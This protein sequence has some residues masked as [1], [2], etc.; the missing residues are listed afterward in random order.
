M[1]RTKASCSTVKAVAAKAPRKALAAVPASADSPSS[2]GKGKYAGGNPAHP[3]PTPSWQ[4]GL[5]SFLLRSPSGKGKE[6]RDDE[7]PSAS[8]SSGNE[9]KAKSKLPTKS[10]ATRAVSDSGSD[11][12]VIPE[13]KPLIESDEDE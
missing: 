4:K 9:T 3:R 7:G 12:E 2:T 5:D 1:V 13:K 8:T 6:N 11:D 10:K